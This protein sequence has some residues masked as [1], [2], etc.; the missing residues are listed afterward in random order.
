MGA[1]GTL[2]IGQLRPRIVA[3]FAAVVVASFGVGGAAGYAVRAVT[4]APSASVDTST[5]HPFAVQSPPYQ[6]PA[7]S[8]AA[9]PTFRDPKGNAVP[10]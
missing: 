1:Q 6:I 3:A 8:P 2:V 7:T 4:F 9:I 10:I 5:R